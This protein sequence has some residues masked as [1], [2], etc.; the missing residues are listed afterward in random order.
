MKN[1]S[2]IRQQCITATADLSGATKGQLMAWLEN[3]QFDTNTYPR[4]KQRIYDEENERW[5]TLQN[6]PIQGRQSMAKGSSI[7]LVQPIEFSTASWRR[8]V[9]SLEDHQKAWL[10]WSYS[11]N[12]RFEYQVEITRWAWG[13]LIAQLCSKKIAAK[14]LD[15][16]RALI[17]L[18]AQDVKS[19][20]A[21][22]D[23]YQY[24]E[25]ALL[26][27]VED[28]NWSKTFTGHW[29]SM[30]AI[31]LR[32][33]QSSLLSVS[34]TRSEQIATNFQRGIAKVD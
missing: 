11:E 10:L 5:I 4:K 27:G 17:W 14:T 12:T 32:L 29:L 31:F 20:L 23:V 9:L 19:E 21:G 2:Y 24:Q 6:P 1:L 33:D 34:K 30:R 8:A 15:R 18:A 22:R 25:L 16:L 13:E 3:A 26:V 7:A 28:K